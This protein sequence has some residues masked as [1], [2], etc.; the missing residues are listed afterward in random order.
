MK[1]LDP[2]SIDLETL[3]KSFQYEKI[4]R[5]LDECDNIDEIR[6]AAKCFVKLYLKTT[7]AMR[8]L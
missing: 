1:D 7:E 3:S 2:S 4:S 8:G 5:E 6:D